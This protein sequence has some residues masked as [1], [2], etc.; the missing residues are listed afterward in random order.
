MS[1]EQRREQI[2]D[3]AAAIFAEKGFAGAKTRDIADAC[4]VSEA[5]VFRHFENKSTLF[6]ASLAHCLARHD[7]AAFLEGL[8]DDTPLMDQFK[9]V[10]TKIL[11]IG[12]E[13]TAINRLL[14]TASL[15]G[16]SDMSTLYITWRVPFIEHLRRVVALGIDRG[17]LRP[18]DPLLTARAFVGLVMDC[19]LSCDLWNRMGQEQSAPGA[20]IENNVPTFVLGLMKEKPAGDGRSRE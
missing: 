1:A 12:L 15:A 8:D 10:G 20:L 11:E 17:D 3:R 14:L 9:L 2:L 4:G 7:V 6:N 19:V 18:V 16:P 5:V 13:D